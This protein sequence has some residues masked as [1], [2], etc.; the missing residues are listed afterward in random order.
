MN[1]ERVSFEALK[2]RSGVCFGGF[3]PSEACGAATGF[4]QWEFH[5]SDLIIKSERP[6]PN[7]CAEY[8][9]FAMDLVSSLRTAFSILSV[10]GALL[11]NGKKHQ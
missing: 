2:E 3:H 9:T 5:F 6:C 8:D 1:A 10:Q 11:S 4:S 7:E